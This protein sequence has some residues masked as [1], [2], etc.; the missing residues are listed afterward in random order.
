M[1]LNK[2]N[3]FKKSKCTKVIEIVSLII[4]IL[5]I[6]VGFLSFSNQLKI[7][8]ELTANPDDLK[9]KIIFS[10]HYDQEKTDPIIAETSDINVTAEDAIITNSQE[11]VI[12]NLS[13]NF[14]EPGQKVKYNFYIYNAGEYTGYL[15]N[16]IYENIG[17]SNTPKLCITENGTINDSIK[18][19][20][21]NI[22][23]V[24][25]VANITTS[26]SLYDINNSSLR[27]RTAQ[28]VEVTI[29]YLEG[30]QSPNETFDVLFGDIRLDYSLFDEEQNVT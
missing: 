25:K 3:E 15:K 27:P 20:C 18:K 6:S 13:A 10:S 23:I 8:S 9:F 16:I 14:T 28:S 30:T 26:Q 29:E 22:R 7:Q 4:A 19:A 21:D 2:S 1:K 11:P 5:S 24:I 17:S 12:T